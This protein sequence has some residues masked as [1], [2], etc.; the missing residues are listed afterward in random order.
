[1]HPIRHAGAPLSEW[2]HRRRSVE[3]LYRVL[4][5]IYVLVKALLRYNNSAPMPSKQLDKVDGS[6]LLLKR[7]KSFTAIW[8]LFIS[9]IH[10]SRQPY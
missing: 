6:N 2:T 9:T 8:V 3:K 5:N 4:S 10:T 1:M 7:T